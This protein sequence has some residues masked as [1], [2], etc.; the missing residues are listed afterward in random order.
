LS[1]PNTRNI[2]LIA[3]TPF[4]VDRGGHIHI[5]EQAR[6]LQ[7]LGNHVTMVTYHIGKDVP[8]F[9]I[10]RIINIPWYD[11]LDA[12]PSYHKP[13]LAILLLWK[14]LKV[15]KDIKPDIVHAHGWD[16]QWVAWWL[17]K[18]L[19]I[20]FI[21]D[22]QGS[23][24]GEISE[25]GYTNKESLYFKLLSGI[26]RLSLNAS[27]V[28]VTSSTQ[29]CQQSRERF[30]LTEDHLWPILDG[31]D[32]DEFSPQRFPYEPELFQQLGLPENK[33]II[34]YMGLLKQYQGVDDMIEAARVLIYEREYTDAHFLVLGFPDE[35]VYAAKAADKGLSDYMTFT[36]KVAYHETGRYMAL[37]DL[38]IAPKIAVTEGDAKIYFYMAMGLPV[39]AYEREASVEILGDLGLYAEFKNPIDLARTLHEALLDPDLL[40]QRGRQNREKAVNEYS[41]TAVANRVMEAYHIA[42][43]R[44]TPD[45]VSRPHRS[46]VLS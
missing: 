33:Q 6:A 34:V 35:D 22:M 8:D 5:Y 26:E 32:T 1:E 23:F 45:R 27:P 37:A 46:E 28:V 12:G 7:E 24:S 31:V 42:E 4:F 17:W 14:A 18:L 2:L 13:Y 10:H 3:A 21:F 11:K 39:V 15:A 29:I 44:M 41:W 38:A 9:D 36:G 30:G 40:E 16:S 19:G 20:P 25:H 43:Q